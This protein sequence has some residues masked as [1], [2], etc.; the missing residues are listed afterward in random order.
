MKYHDWVLQRDYND[1]EKFISQI[2]VKLPDVNQL[3]YNA[4]IK[5][6]DR[7][8][9]ATN[10]GVWIHQVHDLMDRN[11]FTNWDAYSKDENIEVDK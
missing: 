7:D 9:D 3:N 2:S 5:I 1:Y 4:C 6:D 10:P 11:K 8:F